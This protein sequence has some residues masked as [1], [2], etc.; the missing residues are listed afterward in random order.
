M[1]SRYKAQLRHAHHY[2][3]IA[4][5]ADAV[6]G[7]GGEYILVGLDLFDRERAQI[8]IGW[9][10]ARSTASATEADKLIVSFANA[11]V[12]VAELRFDA[13]HERIPYLEDA[14]AAACRLNDRQAEGMALGNM[15]LA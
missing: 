6:Y 10:W 9:A 15:G 12:N 4:T 7:K 1:P 5:Q 3:R 14:L 8:E 2:V 13:R 11:V